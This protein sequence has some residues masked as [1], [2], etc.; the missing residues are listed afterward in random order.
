MLPL[1]ATAAATNK[2]DLS[3]LVCFIQFADDTEEEAF[4]RPFPAYDKLFNDDRPD[5][6]SL[7]NYFKRASYGQLS[8]RTGFFPAPNSGAVVACRT[9]YERG[10]YQPYQAGINDSGYKDDVAG[11]ARLQ[12]LAIEIAN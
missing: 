3:N 4:T 10:Y 7:F 12:A 9:K 1:R 5:S 8:W 2:G 11:A 6:L